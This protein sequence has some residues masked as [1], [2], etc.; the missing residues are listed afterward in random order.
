MTGGTIMSAT[1]K[2]AARK[3]AL[4]ELGELLALKALVDHGFEGIS[5]LNDKKM[6][7]PFADLVASR[8]GKKYVISIKARNKY[9]KDGSLNGGY[10]LGEKAHEHALGAA[11]AESAVPAWMAVQFDKKNYSIFFG[12]LS[13][14]NGKKRIP[15][16][17]LVREG[18]GGAFCLEFERRH[19]FD[20]SYFENEKDK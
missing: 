8:N 7:Y 16:R 4:G 5:N 10:K 14:L 12:E 2:E 18:L 9:Q 13:D 3:K 11:T 15:V 17:H 19:F 20:A 1:I 6:N